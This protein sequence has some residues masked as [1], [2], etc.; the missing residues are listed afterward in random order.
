MWVW[1]F[2]CFWR[3]RDWAGDSC[4]STSPSPISAGFW[5]VE[6]PLLCQLDWGN[7][8][9]LNRFG[10][11]LLLRTSRGLSLS[12][13]AKEKFFS[14]SCRFLPVAGEGR[15]FPSRTTTALSVVTFSGGSFF[16]P[17]RE[18][19]RVHCFALVSSDLLHKCSCER[20]KHALNRH[21]KHNLHTVS[22][23]SSSSSIEHR[24]AC[25]YLYRSLSYSLEGD[26][27]N[28]KREEFR[29]W[30]SPL[31]RALNFD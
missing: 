1:E 6:L 3:P 29:V 20:L 9:R 19:V 30:F 21:Y 18:T 28:P 26:A 25:V 8:C 12:S 24:I 27:C 31:A 15:R 13:T 10:P 4:N 14:P 7:R 17:G 22:G 16:V 2:A 11:L 23:V 5:G